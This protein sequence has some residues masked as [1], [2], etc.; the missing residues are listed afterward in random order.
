MVR[1][2]GMCGPGWAV[3]MRT[4][5][6]APPPDP[7]DWPPATYSLPPHTH[8][9]ALTRGTR[10]GAAW[11]ASGHVTVA[12]EAEGLEAPHPLVLYACS[13]CGWVWVGMGG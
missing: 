10:G 11:L 13:R 5:P 12:Q 4:G 8:E 2:C 1:V 3:S 6:P 7:T 9:P